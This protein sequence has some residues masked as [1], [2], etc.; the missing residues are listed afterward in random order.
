[1]KVSWLV[2][3]FIIRIVFFISFLMLMNSGCAKKDGEHDEISIN[4]TPSITARPIPSWTPTPTPT[5]VTYQE[6]K[7]ALLKEI[8]KG[9]VNSYSLSPDGS[10]VALLA[11]NLLIW[12]DSV[13]QE[14]LGSVE[15]ETDWVFTILISPNNRWILIDYMSRAIIDTTTGEITPIYGFVESSGYSTN[16]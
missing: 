14:V 13:S 1:M 12:Q 9:Y 6:E 8:G 4:P 7:P 16:P 2:C 5:Q 15:L 10:L 11:N 3:R